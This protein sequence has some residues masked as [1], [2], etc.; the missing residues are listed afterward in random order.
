MNPKA[1]AGNTAIAPVFALRPKAGAANEYELLIYGDIGDSFWDDSIAARDVVTQLNE[2]DDAVTQ[3]N[4]RIN[5]FGG[6]VADGLAIYN[7][8]RRNKAK[9]LVSIDGVAM[10]IASLI[11]MAGD[12]IQMP[13][14]AIMMIHAPWGIAIGNANDLRLA[15]DSLDTHSAA[16][17]GAYT[18]KSGKTTDEML[19]I[20]ED[21]QDHYYTGEQAVAEG[22]A[23]TLLGAIASEED[24]A[25]PDTAARANAR[26]LDRFIKR[27]P[28]QRL[29]AMAMS[30]FAHAPAFVPVTGNDHQEA[31]S[32][33]A[34]SLGDPMFKKRHTLNSPE[35]EG[36]AGG[37]ASAAASGQPGNAIVAA[38]AEAQAAAVAA[39]RDRNT[40]INALLK[41]HLDGGNTSI[42]A[43][44]DQAL[45]DPS[46]TIDV[47]KDR[48]LAK[49]GAQ[50]TPSQNGGTSVEGGADAIDK[51]R[52]AMAQALDARTGRAKADGANPFRGNSLFDVARACASAANININ[53]LDRVQI[54]QAAITHS[55]S[56]F[57]LLLGNSVRKSVLRGYQ[58][59][60]EVYP[61]FTGKVNVPD[62][63]T[64]S[65]AGLGLF[66]GIRRIPENGEYKYGTFTELGQTIKVSKRG[67]LFSIS[68]EAIINDDL[69]AFSVIPEKMG[70][71]AKTNLGD[72]VFALLTLNA[73]LAD[74]VPLFHATHRNLLTA[75][76]ISTASVGSMR[77]AMAVQKNAKNEPARAPLKFLVVPVGLG[78]LARTV[79]Q[80][81]FEVGATTRNNSTPNVVRNS[82]VVVEDPRLDSNSATAWYGVADPAY[83]DSIVIAYRDG[84]EEPFTD[85]KQ[86]WEVDGVEF[87]VRLEAEPAIADFVGLAKNPG[88]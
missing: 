86:G 87:K 67:A 81:E 27:M 70:R 73:N 35:G 80:S 21:W 32:A 77:A 1:K 63:K 25:K 56:D 28:E 4:V 16:M 82:F 23:D 60:P 26:G 14:T 62:F 19:A 84:N 40:Q 65:L 55:T 49:L 9:K 46:I 51:R 33:S 13:S 48:A 3:I 30:A 29:A 42:R 52:T 12:E 17:V 64:T 74:G 7:A 45:M 59:F 50:A 38:A 58:D 20:L 44:Y 71:A 66:T 41:P 10:S 68:Y 2:L 22:F 61:D 76:A 85:Q 37:G 6:S 11:A 57:P 39:I 88:V 47:V 72:D 15:A 78:D 31:D 53:G 18:A 75:A 79:L 5:S 43:L 8:L 83:V 34:S 54:V 36:G 24:P 69:N